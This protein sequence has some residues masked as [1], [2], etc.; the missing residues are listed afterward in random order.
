[1]TRINKALIKAIPTASQESLGY[2]PDILFYQHDCKEYK[3]KLTRLAQARFIYSDGY[4]IRRAGFLRFAFESIKGMLG[5]INHCEEQK[6]RL[7]LQKFAFYGYLNS[8]PQKNLSG[9]ER[10]GLS[11]DYIHLVS[12]ARNSQNSAIIQADLINFYVANQKYFPTSTQIEQPKISKHYTFGSTLSWLKF[13]SQIP[14]L[15]PQDTQLIAQTMQRLEPEANPQTYLFLPNSHYSLSV[16]QSYVAKAREKRNNREKKGSTIFSMISSR[17]S[18]F[19]GRQPNEILFQ[20]YLERALLFYPD[21]SITEKNL[22]IE[23]YLEK[24]EGEK[25]FS[26]IKLLTNMEDALRYLCLGQFTPDQL[27][28]WKVNQD[29]PLAITLCNSYL[30]KNA[31]NLKI[32]VIEFIASLLSDFS[33]QY[34]IYAFK[35]M[36]SQ[37]KYDEAYELFNNP[38]NS[39]IQFLAEDKKLL[40]E[41]FA[42]L[43]EKYNKQGT[44]FRRERNWSEAKEAYLESLEAKKRAYEL[45]LND[46]T[47]KELYFEQK[48]LYALVLIDADKNS[49]PISN[50]D[51]VELNKAI[52]LLRECTPEAS[53]TIACCLTALANGLMRQVDYW[54]NL[55]LVPPLYSVNS[56]IEKQHFEKHKQNFD[57][58]IKTLNEI[59]SLL[60]KTNDKELKLILGKAYFLLADINSYFF[61]QDSYTDYFKAMKTVPLNPIYTMRCSEVTSS[62]QER[63]RLQD[64]SIKQL[65]KRGFKNPAFDY[66]HWF[67]D[68]WERV[69]TKQSST[70]EIHYQQNGEGTLENIW[71]SNEKIPSTIFSTFSMV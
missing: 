41:H 57:L 68:R 23:Y 14:N 3:E 40:T 25:A 24:N 9:L 11:R 69:K 15:D 46:K 50:C 49:N 8:Y 39:E 35:L 36:I 29:S 63:S 45:A 28:Q 52:R 53:K 44:Q 70:T 47:R 31:K 56:E 17:L 2:Y 38:K 6:V 43:G 4:T 16:A 32:A 19:M 18:S 12:Q 27:Q 64:T 42:E 26:L 13:W 7:S 67:D 30:A 62:Q 10:H 65:K 58:I 37:K 34:P 20:T 71:V 51:I 1:M 55:I 21:I 22:Y 5:F 48:R 66:L 61:S 54:T 60:E 33:K 59:I